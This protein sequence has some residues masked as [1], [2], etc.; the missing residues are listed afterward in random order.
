[1]PERQKETIHTVECEAM[2]QPSRCSAGASPRQGCVP[3][4]G[5]NFPWQDKRL[6]VIRS[7]QGFTLVE[8]VVGLMLAV[9]VIAA[10]GTFLIFGTN[11][12][13]TT[14][15]RS[16]QQSDVTAVASEMAEQLRLAKS[17]EVV[18][19]DTLPTSLEESQRIIFIGD[20]DG[21]IAHTGY[22]YYQNAES[23]TVPRNSYGISWYEGYHIALDYSVTVETGKPK[24]FSVT[25]NCF[26]G[27]GVST[28]TSSTR[29]F[30][31]VNVIASQ[32]P[33][34]SG[35]VNSEDT[36][37][38]LLL[39]YW[40]EAAALEA[41]TVTANGDN[42]LDAE[43]TWTV[44]VSG[45]YLL[46]CWGANGGQLPAGIIN[47]VGQNGFGGYAAGELYL[48]EGTQVFLTAGGAGIYYSSNEGS[49]PDSGE[50]MIPGGFNGGGG[51][52]MSNLG[53]GSRSARTSGGGANDIRVVT[54]DLYH[55]IVVAGGG[56]GNSG[57]D[58]D[59]TGGNGGGVA[60][61]SGGTPGLPGSGGGGNQLMGG[62]SVA[63]GAYVTPSGFGA[64]SECRSRSY[65]AGGGWYGG[66]NGDG[67]G[68]GS[69]YVLTVDSVKP[70]GYFSEHAN[71]HLSNT[72]NVQIAESGY[73][74]KPAESGHGG[75]VR[76][77]LI[78][79]A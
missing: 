5:N 17:V 7:R 3:A 66:G 56:G 13:S 47:D 59:N 51:A 73:V 29:S 32:K 61:A 75:Y 18:V 44:P 60:G 35:H 1:M 78:G 50:N 26:D 9:V 19:S 64:G 46:E 23:D 15:E 63:S 65:M 53:V 54:N 10:A 43:K 41:T 57:S 25:I 6:S 71:Y 34:S 79:Q 38:Y 27:N 77:T 22:Y 24:R 37:F 45:Y 58:T 16:F 28:S 11:L 8:L 67:A 69:G 12:L 20:K 2:P 36:L 40:T 42:P 4:A 68:G 21:A 76:I 49:W 52:S 70:T 55:R 62:A 33:T 48:A 39:N 14:A 30:E 74:N 72:V 31:F